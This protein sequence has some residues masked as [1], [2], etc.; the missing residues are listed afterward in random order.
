MQQYLKLYHLLFYQ[1]ISYIYVRLALQVFTV[2]QVH[3]SYICCNVCLLSIKFLTY[4][5]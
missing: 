1:V 2:T 3:T 5:Q 4:I